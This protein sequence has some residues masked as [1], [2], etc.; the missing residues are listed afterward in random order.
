[1]LIDS[2][3]PASTFAAQL[4]DRWYALKPTAGGYALRLF[5]VILI[6]L[7][8]PPSAYLAAQRPPPFEIGEFLRITAPSCGFEEQIARFLRFY[9]D[10]LTVRANSEVAI[11]LAALTR[12]DVSRGISNRP[13]LIGIAAGASAGILLGIVFAPDEESSF[14]GGSSNTADRILNTTNGG[15]SPSMSGAAVGPVAGALVGGFLGGLLGKAMREHRWEEFPLQELRIGVEPQH[16]GASLA[17][18][19]SF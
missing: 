8:V 19:F 12:L 5:V 16:E 2:S 3:S 10:T 17:L 9:R 11:P 7:L 1:M 4:P 14:G 15:S 18:R 6:P 13:T